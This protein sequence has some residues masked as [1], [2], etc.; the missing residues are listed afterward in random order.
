MANYETCATCSRCHWMPMS[1]DSHEIDEKGYCLVLN[2]YTAYTADP[3]VQTCKLSYAC[4]AAI[5]AGV[6]EAVALSDA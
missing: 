4:K 2:Q 6:P 3:F 5:K 1:K